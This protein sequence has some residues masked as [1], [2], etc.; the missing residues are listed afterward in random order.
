MS[1]LGD[2]NAV[3]A[4]EATVPTWL[5]VRFTLGDGREVT[6]RMTVEEDAEEICAV[7]PCMHAESDYLNYVP[8]EFSFSVEEEKK[9]IR[10][11][12][13]KPGSI[14][15]V[16]VDDG[17]IIA[18]AGAESPEFKRLAH[19][20]ELGLTVAKEFW[21][22]G[23]GRK[24]MDCLLKWGRERGLRKMY[25]RVFDHNE[26]GLRLYRSL[27]FVEEGRFKGDVRRGDGT[28]GDTILMAKHFA[29]NLRT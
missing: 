10:K 11:H 15:M 19:H 4:K 29:T 21:G 13:T 1:D 23:I 14:S 20:A 3:D 7:L 22:E 24:L 12:T 6:I 28:Y 9:Y 17:R 18:L 2:R 25:L 26:R 8:G 27:G 5:P 16:A